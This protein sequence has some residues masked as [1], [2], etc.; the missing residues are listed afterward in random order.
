MMRSSKDENHAH[1]LQNIVNLLQQAKEFD[2]HNSK[3][4]LNLGQ[5]FFETKQYNEV[6]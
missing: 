4:L 3:V 6:R 1:N 5:T 2:P